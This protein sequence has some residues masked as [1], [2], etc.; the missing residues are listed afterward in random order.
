[1]LSLT[2]RVFGVCTHIV[3]FDMAF[4]YAYQYPKK[5]LSVLLMICEKV[6]F[7]LFRILCNVYASPVEVTLSEGRKRYCRFSYA[8]GDSR[9]IEF[10]VS[11]SCI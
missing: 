4:T 9:I 10:P 11:L 6:M 1:M 5:F 3:A 2:T 7:L 8:P